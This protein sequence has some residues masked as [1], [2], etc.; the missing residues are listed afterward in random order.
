[1]KNEG[2]VKEKVKQTL[3]R[4]GA[5]WYMPVPTGF[6]KQ[7]VSDFLV[8]HKGLFIA[9]ETKFGGNKP[10]KLQANYGT[11]VAKAGGLFL[12][13]DENNVGTLESQIRYHADNF[14]GR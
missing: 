12:V 14:G 8:C 6:G 9:I 2:A 13:I 5:H 1:M 3:K 10:T 7:G 4:M 11:E